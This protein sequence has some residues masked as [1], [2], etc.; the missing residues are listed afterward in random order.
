MQ[1]EKL[2]SNFLESNV[3]I[4]KCGNECFI[5]DSGVELGEIKKSVQ[6][7]KVLGVLLTH[8]HYDHAMFAEI[9]AK[10]FGCKIYTSEFAKEEL[11][12]PAKNY[13]ESFKLTS[14]ED[15]LFLDNNGK[16]KLGSFEIEYFSTPGHCKSC[17]CFL[18]E[19]HLFAGDTL[20]DSSIGR[21]DLYGSSKDDMLSSL[22]KLDN[23][24]FE[25]CH[26]G[27]GDD[28]DYARQKRNIKI[29][30]RFLQR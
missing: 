18:Y 15:F 24:S 10:E 12:D 3:F 14:F 26:S 8:G 16:L 25:V 11:S 9:Y 2:S 6:G 13:G 1:I 27:H 21:T 7:L 23:I 20:F 4:A 19:T 29:F 5:V 22:A 28:S 30:T 17:L